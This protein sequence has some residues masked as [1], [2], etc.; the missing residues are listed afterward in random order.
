M[1][2]S[3]RTPPRKADIGKTP[4][5]RCPVSTPDVCDGLPGP[6]RIVVVDDDWIELSRLR[7]VIEQTFDC[8]VVSACRCAEGAMLAVER[9]RPAVVIL[10]VRMPDHDGIELIRDI[11]A[12][13]LNVASFHLKSV[14][15]AI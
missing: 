15:F 5:R 3:A 10:D 4:H 2:S 11:I 7:E 6:N 13:S 14:P 12:V 9:Y 8:V 1:R